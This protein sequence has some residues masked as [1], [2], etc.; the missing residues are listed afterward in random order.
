M[1]H[2]LWIVHSSYQS[3][4][5]KGQLFSICCSRGTV[6]CVLIPAVPASQPFPGQFPI[7]GGGGS[8]SS[9]LGALCFPKD[10]L[11]LEMRQWHDATGKCHCGGWKI[12]NIS[13][14]LSL[15]IQGTQCPFILKLSRWFIQGVIPKVLGWRVKSISFIKAFFYVC[16][17]YTSINL[18]MQSSINTLGTS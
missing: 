4:E 15:F 1:Y 11:P 17:Q 10:F 18:E 7:M 12:L 2:L 13:V 8:L 6:C 16:K 3:R 9:C 5:K 14:T